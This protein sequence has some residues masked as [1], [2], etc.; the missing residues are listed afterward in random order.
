MPAISVFSGHP[1]KMADLWRRGIQ[2]NYDPSEA[3]LASV[4]P[5]DTT[6]LHLGLLQLVEVA[7]AAGRARGV[8]QR[9]ESCV[10]NNADLYMPPRQSLASGRRERIR[11]DVARKKRTDGTIL[12][13][14][15]Y[16]LAPTTDPTVT[17]PWEGGKLDEERK[18]R[19]RH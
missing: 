2:L 6:Q 14:H 4:I 15:L 8:L 13:H 11:D 5:I 3:R 9:T 1:K 7:V 18:R 12:T 16:P 19:E 17:T 10:Q